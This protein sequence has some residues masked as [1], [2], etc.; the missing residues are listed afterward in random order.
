[1][2]NI[3]QNV[4][5]GNQRSMTIPSCIFR[6]GGAAVLLSNKRTHA[7]RAKCVQAWM[8]LFAMCARHV[9]WIADLEPLNLPKD[10]F[11]IL[12]TLLSNPG[13]RTPRSA[14]VRAAA[15]CSRAHGLAGTRRK[16]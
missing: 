12:Q 4:Y 8:N 5:L 2:E 9:F 14:Q 10:T 15:P 16:L 13:Q 3:S 7:R 1:M 6:L 11:A